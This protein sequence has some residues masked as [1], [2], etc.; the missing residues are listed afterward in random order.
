M[1][2]NQ[3]IGYQPGIDI[4]AHQNNYVVVA[5]SEGYQWLNKNPIVTAPKSLV[6]ISIVTSIV[7]TLSLFRCNV[8]GYIEFL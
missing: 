2:V 6:V 1:R 4:K 5:P 8:N 7:Y 3:L